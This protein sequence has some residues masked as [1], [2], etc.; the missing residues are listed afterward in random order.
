MTALTTT[1]VRALEQVVDAGHIA[2]LPTDT[3]YGLACDPT[4]SRATA[5]MHALKGRDSP[6]ASAILFGGLQTALEALDELPER[7]RDAVTKLLP[8]ALTLL[9]PNPRG[10]WPHAGGYALGLRVP[11]FDGP[12]APLADLQVPLLQTSAN[13]TGAEPPCRLADVPEQ[14]RRVTALALDGGEL[15]GVASTVVDLREYEHGGDVAIVREG[16]VP[17]S[18]VRTRLGGGARGGT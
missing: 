14:I 3:V 9:L 17:E 6:R 1:D 13:V 8:G 7:T 18:T 16:A 12:L 4:Q 11:R 2:I 15:P 5:R 10:R